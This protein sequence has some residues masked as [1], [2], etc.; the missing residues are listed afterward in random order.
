MEVGRCEWRSARR[1]LVYTDPTAR[2]VYEKVHAILGVCPTSFPRANVL[3]SGTVLA[4]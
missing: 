4:H 3:K 1:I 2:V